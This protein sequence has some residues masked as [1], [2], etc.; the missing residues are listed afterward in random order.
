MLAMLASYTESQSY[1]IPLGETVHTKVVLG[2]DVRHMQFRTE[3][4]PPPPHEDKCVSEK[5]GFLLIKTPN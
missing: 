1:A 2:V 3:G 5:A 4:E